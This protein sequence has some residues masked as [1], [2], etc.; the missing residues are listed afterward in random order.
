[1]R[2]RFVVLHRPVHGLTR[3]GIDAAILHEVELEHVLPFLVEAR[4]VLDTLLGEV[5][6]ELEDLVVQEGGVGG[7]RPLEVAVVEHHRV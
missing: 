7:N 2:T 3:D 1:M 6:V 4:T 5:G